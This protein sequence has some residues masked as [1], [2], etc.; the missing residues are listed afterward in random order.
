MSSTRIPR[1]QYIGP[2]PWKRFEQSLPVGGVYK[3]LF[4]KRLSEVDFM[5]TEYLGDAC[6]LYNPD[7]DAVNVYGNMK[8]Y[9]V[10]ALH[11]LDHMEQYQ[12][13]EWFILSFE[14]VHD[15]H[16]EY[17]GFTRELHVK[18]GWTKFA[19]EFDVDAYVL[20]QKSGAPSKPVDLCA[21]AITITSPGTGSSHQLTKL[22]S[23]NLL[24]S[25]EG[26]YLSSATLGYSGPT[27]GTVPIEMTGSAAPGFCH[28]HAVLPSLKAGRYHLM[29]KGQGDSALAVD[30]SVQLVTDNWRCIP[31]LPRWQRPVGQPIEQLLSLPEGLRHEVYQALLVAWSP[32]LNAEAHAN[33]TDAKAVGQAGLANEQKFKTPTTLN[34]W[35]SVLKNKNPT[36]YKD[37]TAALKQSTSSTLRP[38]WVYVFYLS[39]VD[40]HYHLFKEYRAGEPQ[41]EGGKANM[42]MSGKSHST[43]A[44][45]LSDAVAQ[46]E[47]LFYEVDLTKQGF[48]NEREATAD[49]VPGV[50]VP[51]AT[52]SGQNVKVKICHSETQWS[53]PRIHAMG[54]ISEHDPR[55]TL[56]EKSNPTGKA[57]YDKCQSA[58]SQNTA[59]KR[60]QAR[61]GQEFAFT[62]VATEPMAGDTFLSCTNDVVVYGIKDQSENT[63]LPINLDDP[64]GNASLAGCDVFYFWDMLGKVVKDLPNALSFDGEDHFH[65]AALAYQFY[66]NYKAD[67]LTRTD[68][69]GVAGDGKSGPGKVSPLY[70]AAKYL[71]RNKIEYTLRVKDRV[72][73]HLFIRSLQQHMVDC[74]NQ[75][76]TQIKAQLKTA[77]E[78]QKAK[79][80]SIPMNPGAVDINE[81]LKDHFAGSAKHLGPSYMRVLHLI[82]ISAMTPRLL[83]GS[84]TVNNRFI[85]TST[86]QPITGGNQIVDIT[87][88]VKL[89]NGMQEQS[90]HF[91]SA[92]GTQTFAHKFIPTPDTPGLIYLNTLF[93]KDHPLYNTLFAKDLAGGDPCTN[94]GLQGNSLKLKDNNLIST[95]GDGGFFPYG[96][97][98]VWAQ[99]KPTD[100]MDSALDYMS[101]SATLLQHAMNTFIKM[102][103]R[104]WEANHKNHGK[105]VKETML[106]TMSYGEK[107]FRDGTITLEKPG[108]ATQGY[109]LVGVKLLNNKDKGND[110]ETSEADQTQKAEHV[111]KATTIDPHADTEVYVHIGKTGHLVA[112]S[113]PDHHTT[114]ATT[115]D[116]EPIWDQTQKNA[117]QKSQV[118]FTYIKDPFKL[119]PFL[120]HSSRAMG[121]ILASLAL[122]DIMD[123]MMSLGNSQNSAGYD[124]TE[125]LVNLQNMAAN[126][127]M[128]AD[129]LLGPAA[130]KNTL[131]SYSSTRWLF[132]DIVTNPGSVIKISPFDALGLFGVIFTAGVTLVDFIKSFSQDDPALKWSSGFMFAGNGLLAAGK[133]AKHVKSLSGERGS[134]VENVTAD[135]PNISDLTV[136]TLAVDDVPGDVGE[137]MIQIAA[138]AGTRVLSLFIPAFDIFTVGMLVCTLIGEAILLFRDTKFETW[139]KRSAFKSKGGE[140]AFPTDESAYMALL[141][142]L[143]HPYLESEIK[144]NQNL[145]MQ[146]WLPTVNLLRHPVF[147]SQTRWEYGLS[148]FTPIS[149]PIKPINTKTLILLPYKKVIGKQYEYAPAIQDQLNTWYTTLGESLNKPGASHVNEAVNQS[150]QSKTGLTI[151]LNSRTQVKV[152]EHTLPLDID[153]GEGN[154]KPDTTSNSFDQSANWS[155]YQWKIWVQ[156]YE[157]QY[158]IKSN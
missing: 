109:K 36:L 67:G 87:R 111:Q 126:V 11:N 43:Q 59:K 75:K 148:L 15:H 73:L 108:S 146:A 64:L 50:L 115:E 83:D 112:S 104:S 149:T 156:D 52:S 81:C 44:T 127:K 91:N 31:V 24:V 40:N 137:T 70:M 55:F 29:A 66:F 151:S 131:D 71:N 153:W 136:D 13:D 57:L 118:E 7:L 89:P 10:A 133:V 114:D 74:L 154:P 90:S 120:K 119:H 53:W 35:Q 62:P 54:D 101:Y 77:V 63:P 144:P 16:A 103:T 42:D 143:F 8:Q 37:V 56:L 46:G 18:P 122:I 38:G 3:S 34:N 88:Y 121:G 99:A 138:R 19:P 1:Y 129:D 132:N 94:V 21:P 82:S 4:Y 150:Y 152:G 41:P 135:S 157:Q 51:F 97:A 140:Q 116:G 107:P 96:F 72:V 79:L 9:K 158:H 22:D 80:P 30:E 128:L 33:S 68:L 105:I 60:L 2:E 76:S 147:I 95:V 45:T 130:V 93:K 39:T 113:N 85:N 69:D 25:G 14:D 47:Q 27:S 26:M 32:A 28:W 61:A 142:L 6:V 17:V 84:F 141:S 12:A 117:F 155:H 124:L 98:H 100:R 145:I 65:S 5:A 49:S 139:A 20:A 58:G 106:N 125:L 123:Q 92:N 86:T 48:Q 78:R 23:G 110:S 102:A 134:L